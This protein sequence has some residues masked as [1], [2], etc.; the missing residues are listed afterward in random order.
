M[1]QEK[2]TNSLTHFKYIKRVKGKNGK[3]IYYYDKEPKV[4]N[5]LAN[6]I[7]LK[8]VSIKPIGSA[9]A[10]SGNSLISN[11]KNAVADAKL[12]AANKAYEKVMYSA[13]ASIQSKYDACNEYIAKFEDYKKTDAY[14]AAVKKKG[15]ASVE[16]FYTMAKR[17][18]PTL[19]TML[20]KLGW[21]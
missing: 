13:S 19:A 10:N 11:A 17:T 9:V 15:K 18:L 8:N 14:T 21:G 20:S 1:E 3:Y 16:R 7:A 4:A 6:T 12:T 2:E 5:K